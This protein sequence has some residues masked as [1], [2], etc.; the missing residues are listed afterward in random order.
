MENEGSKVIAFLGYIIV[1][2][3]PILG[4]IYGVGL[5][6]LKKDIPLYRKHGRLTIYFAILV[7]IVSFIV[8]LAM[9]GF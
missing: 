9:G 5:F 6:F 1:L 2:L 3:S 8:R 7:F 4:L